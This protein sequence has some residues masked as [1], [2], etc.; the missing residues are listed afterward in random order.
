MNKGKINLKYRTK[1]IA[2]LNFECIFDCDILLFN[3]SLESIVFGAILSHIF[4][5]GIDELIDK[6]DSRLLT[7]NILKNISLLQLFPK[8]ES[9]LV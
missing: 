1:I 4:V 9:K 5:C 3:T 6:S 2:H 8:I 7:R